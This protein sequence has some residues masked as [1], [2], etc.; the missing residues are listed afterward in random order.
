MSRIG[1]KLITIPAGVEVTCTEGNEVTVKGPKGTLT[2]QFSPLM[3][4]EIKDGTATV[5]AGGVSGITG[6]VGSS[7]TWGMLRVPSAA[8]AGVGGVCSSGCQTS[9]TPEVGSWISTSTKGVFPW[10]TASRYSC[11]I[12]STCRTGE[13]KQRTSVSSPSGPA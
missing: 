1:N 2:R 10:A 12:W 8:A 6:S 5:A 3:G 4:I 7:R 9:S 11:S 13:P